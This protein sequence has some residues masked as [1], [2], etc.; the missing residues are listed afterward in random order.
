MNSTDKILHNEAFAAKVL[1]LT[2]DT[3]FYVRKDGL[4][5]D[6]KPN[7]PDFYLKAA[8]VVDKN[9]FEFFPMEASLGLRKQVAHAMDDQGSSQANYEFTVDSEVK[10]FKC[11][12]SKFDQD[13]FIMQYRDITERS[14]NKLKLQRQEQHLKEVEKAAHIGLLLYDSLEQ[15]V[16]F[17]GYAD[18]FG[19]Q[20]DLKRV[21]PLSSCVK[22]IH[23]ADQRAFEQWLDSHVNGDPESQDE[24]AFRMV[25]NGKTMNTRMKVYSRDEM[26]DRVILEGYLQ[27][28]S[29]IVWRSEHNSELKSAF[30]ANMSHEIRTP[31]NAVMGFSRII[32]E[33]DSAAERS[34]YF[35]I[36]ERNNMRLQE[37]INEILDLSKL[38]S[39][40]M[41]FHYAPVNLYTLCEDVQSTY[42][43]RCQPGVELIFDPGCDRSLYI[44]TDRNRLFQVFSNLIGNATKY[45]YRGHISLGYCLKD[46]E[47]V[48]HV[49]DTGTGISSDKLSKIFDRFVMASERVQGTGLGLSISKIIVEK[50]GGKIWVDSRVDLGTTFTFAI[51]YL[52]VDGHNVD[53]NEA[54]RTR[55]LKTRTADD[56]SLKGKKVLVA[57]DDISNYTLVNAIIGKH[58][59]VIH[60]KDGMEAITFFEQHKPDIVLMDIKMPNIN[61]LDATR[62]IREMDPTIPIIAVSAYAYAEDKQAARDSGCN[63]FIAKPVSGDLL[64]STINRYLKQE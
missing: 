12:V 40:M 34:K 4:C 2:Q 52:A 53:I 48:F 63:E 60:A 36:V 58:Y 18:F 54:L 20:E 7:T 43:F 8:D 27:N 35:E 55:P 56:E 17:T 31:L 22:M 26:K 57:E 3:M 5:I 61:G 42:Q 15:Q 59:K 64:R 21:C 29:E 45:T 24:F 19:E 30:L 46:G 25:I 37:L 39:G 14:I 23:E 38:E 13:H 50:L 41:E 16:H 33:S 9:L 51:P 28:V 10:F 6:Y 62:A 44:N 49:S 32:A 47:I 1:E 11:I